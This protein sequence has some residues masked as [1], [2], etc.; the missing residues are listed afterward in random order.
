[1]PIQMQVILKLI[2]NKVFTITICLSSLIF[3]IS[4]FTIPLPKN[5][6]PDWSR[7]VRFSSGEVMRVYLTSDEKWRIFLSLEEID[8]LFV[9]TTIL[10]EDKFFFFHPGFNPFSIIRAIYQNIKAGKVVSGGSTITMQL[11]R[12]LEPK[13]RTIINKL[14]EIFRAMQ[15]E[16]R[17]SKRK[18]LELY[19]NLAPY[20]GN[21][22]GIGAAMLAYYGRLPLNMTPEEVAFLVSMPQSPPTRKPGKN[23]ELSG[24]K[25]ALKVMLKAGFINKEEYEKALK[26]AVPQKRKSFPF[27]AP[28]ISDFLIMKYSLND[29]KSTIK[30]DIQKKIENIVKSYKKRIYNLGATNISVVVIENSTRKVRGTVGSIDYF[31]QKHSGQV[32]GFYAFRSPGSTL[33]PFLYILA[34]EAGLINPETLIEDAPYTFGDFEPK[35]YLNTFRGLVKA[36]EAL[37]LSLNI[38]F[39]LILKRYGYSRFIRKLSELELKGP[40]NYSE[41]GLPIITGG[42]DVRLLDLTNMYVTLAKGGIHGKYLL[43]EGEESE[44]KRVFR[45]GAVLLTLRALS[46]RTRP[47]APNLKNFT[48]P[49]GK[50][51]WKTGTSFGRRDAWAIGFQKEYTVGVWVGNFSGEGADSI[52]GSKCAAPIMFD[53]I[54]A[55]EEPWIGKLKWEEH[56]LYEIEYGSV[57]AF[58]GYRPG[59]ACKK[60]KLV[61]M[62]L[63]AHTYKECPFHKK[64]LIE[65]KTGYRANPYKKYREGEL[66]EKVFL[67]FPPS[68]QIVFGSKGK[69]PEFAPYFRIVEKRNILKITSPVDGAIYIIPKGIKGA[70]TIPLQGFTS[71]RNDTIYWF[72]NGKYIGATRSGEILSIKPEEGELTVSGQDGSGNVSVVCITV[73]KE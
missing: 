9:K 56:A 43:I 38:P 39:I 73:E 48:I 67:V 22:E 41:Y 6:N 26:S 11:A 49:A 31:D 55:L 35:N 20:G 64:F 34:I 1:M 47:D 61:P 69:P 8:P 52:V 46:K 21:I 45:A 33:K 44:E 72:V 66:E 13:E 17:F 40:L 36:E 65:R 25:R 29:I 27:Y 62:L 12:I 60:V 14:L 5:I 30:K 68:V 10:Y 51:F 63:N 71:A 59:P 24:K 4:L 3:Y 42:M 37:S 16:A 7:I 15:F 32:R 28:H 2:K 70:S 50:I 18:I 57:C 54:R 23:P 58:S 19:L 53:I